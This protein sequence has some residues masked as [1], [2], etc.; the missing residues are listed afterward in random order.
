ME[1]WNKGVVLKKE[2][3]GRQTSAIP[4]CAIYIGLHM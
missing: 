3:G 4:K 2:V 1:V